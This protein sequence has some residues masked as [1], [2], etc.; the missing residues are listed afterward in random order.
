LKI[1]HLLFVKVLIRDQITEVDAA[2]HHEQVMDNETELN[3][4]GG[5]QEHLTPSPEPIAD[6][7]LISQ[8]GGKTFE[9]GAVTLRSQQS[10]QTLAYFE[11]QGLI[12]SNFCARVSAWLTALLPVY[13][14][15]F[16]PGCTRVKF[17]G[18]DKVSTTF[19]Y[20]RVLAHNR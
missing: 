12:F 15:S 9:A 20:F 5:T 13:G 19:G 11:S 14:F 10:P 17:Q 16:S 2:I 18:T 3:A 6:S 1:D 7:L 8:T 4:A